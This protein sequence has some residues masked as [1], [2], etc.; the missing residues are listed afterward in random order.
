MP[1][2]V[3]ETGPVPEAWDGPAAPTVTALVSNAVAINARAIFGF[4]T[5]PPW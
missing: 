5:F 1:G 2:P 3:P 4:L